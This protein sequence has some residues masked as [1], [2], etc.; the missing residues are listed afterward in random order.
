MSRSKLY[1]EALTFFQVI[2]R[3]LI[4]I[5]RIRPDEVVGGEILDHL[6][7]RGFTIQPVNSKVFEICEQTTGDTYTLRKNTSDLHV[8]NQVIIEKEYRMLAELVSR[9]SKP[10]AIQCIVDA[11][12]NIGLTS[13]YLSQVFTRAKVLAI[14]PGPENF[15]ALQMNIGKRHSQIIPFQCALWFEKTKMKI[16][17]TFRD[18]REWSLQVVTDTSGVIEAVPLSEI[19]QRAGF[20][21]VDMLK[22]DIEGAEKSLLADLAFLQALKKIKFIAIELH[23][24]VIDKI[25]TI[26]QLQS[27]GFELVYKGET[28]F[29]VN[30]TAL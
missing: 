11:G 16:S 20:A 22:M 9:Y 17:N 13:R 1:S 14:E 26:N 23:E 28:L 6:Q 19:L 7:G 29:G 15:S 27:L 8:F 3:V 18:R 12:A 21:H 24:E 10:E 5:F 30:K 4:H 2:R 25:Q